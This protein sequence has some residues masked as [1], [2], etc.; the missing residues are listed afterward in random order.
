MARH[1]CKGVSISL[2]ALSDTARICDL[3]IALILGV[4]V[5]VAV[6]MA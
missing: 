4:H 5:W 2:V 6:A 3:R 1:A